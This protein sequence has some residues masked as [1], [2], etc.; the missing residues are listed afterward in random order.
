MAS[1]AARVCVQVL[2]CVVTGLEH[3]GWLDVHVVIVMG[4][5]LCV[6]MVAGCLPP[7]PPH[8][9]PPLPHTLLHPHVLPAV[10]TGQGVLPSGRPA[11]HLC[12]GAG[13]VLRGMM[14]VCL[15][16]CVLL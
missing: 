4:L 13:D 16:A 6:V 10:V 3:A 11:H 14:E 8:P 7:P 1:A 9:P 15:S 2:S 5:V 12:V